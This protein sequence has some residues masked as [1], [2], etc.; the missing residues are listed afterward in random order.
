MNDMFSHDERIERLINRKLDGELTHEERLE[1]DRA[2]IRS[3]QHQR[4]LE[5]LQCIDA[6]CAESIR[7]DVEADSGKPVEIYRPVA[8]VPFP[9]RKP[10]RYWWVIPGGIA[11]CLAWFSVSGGL[12][13]LGTGGP[14]AMGPGGSTVIDGSSLTDGRD[15]ARFGQSSILRPVSATSLPPWTG[16]VSDDRR[17]TGVYWV[18]GSDGNIYLIEL[19][20]IQS[21]R[22][23][24]SSRPGLHALNDL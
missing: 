8:H 14:T 19:D 13:G 18:V 24:R 23:P 11:A 4:M 6:V 3:P 17:N 21:Y 1:L 9:N 2:L 16:G 20:R 7:A 10:S 22:R 12:I 15:L 5:E